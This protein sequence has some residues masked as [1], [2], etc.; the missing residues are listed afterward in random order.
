M[1]TAAF[2]PAFQTAVRDCTLRTLPNRI[3]DRGEWIQIRDRA[4]KPEN[5]VV[6]LPVKDPYHIMRNLLLILEILR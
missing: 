3:N 4:G 6:A 1:S 5:R 2:S